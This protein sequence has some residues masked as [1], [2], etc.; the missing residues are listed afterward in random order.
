MVCGCRC[1][2]KQALAYA[3]GVRKPK[4]ADPCVKQ[5]RK[6]YIPKSSKP[7]VG[8]RRCSWRERLSYCG[9]GMIRI[10]A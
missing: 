7:R 9:W 8:K 10:K 6:H 3:A 1:V 4:S 5:L 2:V